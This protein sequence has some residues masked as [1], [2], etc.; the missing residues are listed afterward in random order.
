M[1]SQPV[2]TLQAVLTKWGLRLSFPPMVQILLYFSVRYSLFYSDPIHVVEVEG[3]RSQTSEIT[4][5]SSLTIESFLYF[6]TGYFA[7]CIF[8]TQAGMAAAFLPSL[9][10]RST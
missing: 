1:P 10:E 9:A 5:L 3:L 8:T 2:L 6:H 7:S 4:G